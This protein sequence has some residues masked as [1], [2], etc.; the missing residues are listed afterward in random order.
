MD[1]ENKLLDLIKGIGAQAELTKL[2]YDNFLRVGF[3]PAAA[4]EMTKCAM[5]TQMIIVANMNRSDEHG[6]D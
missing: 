4:L 6:T 3:S 1:G 5:Q 2:Y